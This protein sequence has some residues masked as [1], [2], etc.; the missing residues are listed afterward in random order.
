MTEP[1]VD[2]SD[3]LGSLISVVSFERQDL[4]TDLLTDADLNTLKHLARKGTPENSLRALTSDLAY[5]EAWC[6]AATDQALTWPAPE[7]LA[8]KYVAHHLYDAAERA[9]DPNHGMPPEVEH[10]LRE[11]DL[12]RSQGPQAPATVRRRLSSWATLHRIRGQKGPFD[13]PSLRESVKRAAKAADRPRVRNSRRAI[14]RNI[15]EDL[16]ETCG[17]GGPAALRDRALLSVAFGSGG[18]RRSE[19]AS[20]K[21]KQLIEEEPVPA[22]PEDPE[23]PLLP[24]ITIEL[25]RTKTTD[26]EDGAAVKLIGRPVEA[27]LTWLESENI[28]E[29][30]VFRQVD[31]W[32][33]VGERG[34]TEA[35]IAWVIKS[36]LKSAG[37]DVKD[38]SAHGLRAGYLTQAA[39]DGIPLA[40]AMQQSQHK[41]VQQASEYYNDAEAELS[42]AARLLK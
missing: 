35:G 4:V 36:R 5:L 29:G 27:L 30:Y 16:M 2:S 23:S 3:R 20:L 37:Y 41:S 12:L 22:D 42:R 7:S 28:E 17:D 11:R 24:C 32:E 10:I 40:E 9:R 25:G 15:L 33:N 1:S 21:V 26:A 38:Y 8:L 6:L 13:S 18:R 14:T 31:R 34:M 39:R 19:L